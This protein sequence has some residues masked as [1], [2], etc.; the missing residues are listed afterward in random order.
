MRG[1]I[2]RRSHEHLHQR[3]LC[4]RQQ[5]RGAYPHRR[6]ERELIFT[7]G[8]NELCAT[9]SH[10]VRRL[11]LY[12]YAPPSQRCADFSASQGL[13]NGVSSNLLRG[14]QGVR[15]MTPRPLFFCSDRRHNGHGGT[16]KQGIKDPWTLV[17]S[18]LRHHVTRYRSVIWAEDT[19]IM[20]VPRHKEALR[21]GSRQ[22]R[23]TPAT[24]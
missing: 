19:T 23:G 18:K 12:G 16:M 3:R 13:P 9:T 5:P 6:R 22:R 7:A 1:P 4:T 20:G 15:A 11:G 24:M 21:S 8:R 2:H 10:S 17:L 14:I